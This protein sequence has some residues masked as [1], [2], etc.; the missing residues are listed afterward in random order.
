MSTLLDFL[1]QRS[2]KRIVRTED[3][4]KR[5]ADCHRSALDKPRQRFVGIHHEFYEDGTNAT[6]WTWKV[7][8]R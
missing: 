2:G 7:P 6:L 8:V 3:V 4:Y 5:P 1:N